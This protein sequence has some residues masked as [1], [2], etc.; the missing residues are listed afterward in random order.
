MTSSSIYLQLPFQGILI[1]QSQLPK[2]PNR[3]PEL[4]NE[5][6]MTSGKTEAAF[7]TLALRCGRREL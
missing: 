1:C 2:F 4:I 7:M 6:P 5:E 3:C